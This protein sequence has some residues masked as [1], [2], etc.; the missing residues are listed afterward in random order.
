VA[1]TV[2][3]D[4]DHDLGRWLAGYPQSRRTDATYVCASGETKLFGAFDKLH[5][6]VNKLNVP[7]VVESLE[8]LDQ[9]LV[10]VGQKA[11]SSLLA[12]SVSAETKRVL[13]VPEKD[14]TTYRSI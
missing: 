8:R 10:T 1:E 2:S 13:K 4:T 11:A 3:V 12:V 14:T 7:V 6:R 5:L 9:V